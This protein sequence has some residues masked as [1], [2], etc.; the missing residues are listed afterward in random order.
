MSES[1]DGPEPR[2]PF[3]GLAPALAGRTLFRFAFRSSP[4]PQKGAEDEELATSA[5]TIEALELGGRRRLVI[6][7]ELG[8]ERLVLVGGPNEILIETGFGTEMARPAEAAKGEAANPIASTRGEP[9]ADLVGLLPL[10]LLSVASGL[11][12]GVVCGLFRIAL[13]QAQRFRAA[14]PDWLAERPMLGCA[15]LILGAAVAAG[16]SAGL[17]RRIVPSAAGSG[18]PHVES[19][20]AGESPPAPFALLPVKFIGG[21][22]AIGAGLALGRE[23]PL[24]QMGATCA[25]YVG[26]LFR[27]DWRDSQSLLAAGAGAGLAAA[28]NAPLAGS[29]FVLEELLRR[30]DMRHATA[31]LGASVAAIFV[32]RLIDGASPEF[33]SPSRFAPTAID[34]LLCLGLGVAAG[35]MSVA[36]S[37]AVIGALDMTDRLSRWPAEIKAALIGAAVGALAW[38]APGLVGDGGAL[39]QK[40]IDG[41]FT[42]LA[43][44]LVFLLR[45][46]LGAVSYAAGTPGGL[47]AP[48]LVL[49]AQLGAFFGLLLFAGSPEAETHAAMFAI[50]GMAAFFSAV[51]R[52]PLTG[53]ILITEMTGSS[54]LLLPMLAACFSAMATAALL[55]NAPIY[56]ALR[57]RAASLAGRTGS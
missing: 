40:T 49:G 53:M 9:S 46:V 15:S 57:E 34:N 6:Q 17:V 54:E 1:P 14:V 42:L 3:A 48:L 2:K 23:G 50:V 19:V 20:I 24:V 25:F 33:A 29:A 7:R 51:V 35:V 39:T 16:F 41:G 32:V 43:L 10:G 4:P 26:K 31:A 18:I 52:A 45:F 22:L 5:E 30:F 27:C 44:S 37:A 28:F 11:G 38:F 8:G 21:L 36:Y 13:D 47:F 12:I 56:D 55:R